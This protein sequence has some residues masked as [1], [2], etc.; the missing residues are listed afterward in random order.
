VKSDP[1]WSHRLAEAV[2]A[3]L[4]GRVLKAAVGLL[5]AL[6]AT[7]LL[8]PPSLFPEW[9]F[10]R[11]TGLGALGGATMVVIL[12]LVFP[13]R[14]RLRASARRA[15]GDRRAV[16]RLQVAL[17]VAFALA[18]LG[19]LGLYRLY[20]QGF[21]YDKAV[22]L[23]VPVLVT[24][25]FARVLRGRKGRTPARA[26]TIAALVVG[27]AALTW[28]LVEW[29]SDGLLGTRAFGQDGEDILVDTLLDL[30]LDILG[31]ATGAVAAWRQG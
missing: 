9:L 4:P 8:A 1:R 5:L 27:L 30:S 6:A 31:I 3:V 14:A 2:D 25:P 28:E 22:H 24:Y 18:L 13:M 12:R 11:L 15:A 10:P 16:T 26:A 7:L 19:S 17:A 21:A 29:S 20:R 23:I